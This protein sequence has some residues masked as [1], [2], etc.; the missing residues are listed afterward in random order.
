MAAGESPQ[1][2]KRCSSLSDWFNQNSSYVASRRQLSRTTF[3]QKLKHHGCLGE[4][5]CNKLFSALDR[6]GNGWITMMEFLFGVLAFSDESVD[7]REGGENDWKGGAAGESTDNAVSGDPN[8]NRY[9]EQLRRQI[10]FYAMDQDRDG[11]LNYE[12][13]YRA[14]DRWNP[15]LIRQHQDGVTYE[16]FSKLMTIEP[17]VLDFLKFKVDIVS[18]LKNESE[19]PRGEPS[20]ADRPSPSS[21]SSLVVPPL[22]EAAVAAPGQD[23]WAGDRPGDEPGTYNEG[24]DVC[25]SA[26]TVEPTDA[27]VKRSD[28]PTSCATTEGRPSTNEKPHPPDNLNL[29]GQRGAKTAGLIN[30][31]ATCY[32][33]SILQCLYMEPHFRRLVFEWRQPQ[34]DTLCYQYCL[35][36]QLQQL[37]AF[38][39]EGARTQSTQP[40]TNTFGE[41]YRV[42]TQ[43]DANEFFSILL[44][45][46]ELVEGESGATTTTASGDGAEAAT[47]G[48]A[49]PEAS[50]HG[51]TETG[52]A[53]SSRMSDAIRTLMELHVET[54]T[55]C[56]EC[57]DVSTQLEKA[58]FLTLSVK[59]G[60]RGMKSVE[61]CLEWF[62][63]KERLRGYFCHNCNKETEADNIMKLAKHPEV[64]MLH[65]SRYAY[66]YYGKKKLKH[67][68]SIPPALDLNREPTHHFSEQSLE[69]LFADDKALANYIG[70]KLLNG[71]NVYELQAVVVHSGSGAEGGHYYTLARDAEART[72]HTADDSFISEIGGEDIAKSGGP[73]ETVAFLLLYRRVG[74]SARDL[75]LPYPD[76]TT[77]PEALLKKAKEQYWN[78]QYWN[79][80]YGNNQC[81]NNHQ[82]G[83]GKKNKRSHN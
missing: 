32:M 73:G 6:D 37:F 31:G 19:L 35:R 9:L 54:S 40:L 77:I 30:Q 12:E 51:S 15:E 22:C 69:S 14:F 63:R 62:E 65:L 8:T 53:S 70:S 3:L 66:G 71:P 1:L 28:T 76:P 80:Q 47:Q 13:L 50:G 25:H 68:V 75:L 58:P 27:I 42:T 41:G 72:W 26:V 83:W 55:E 2:I 17:G 18:A 59:A 7:A 78:N 34:D 81:G 36:T 52:A 60:E 45:C 20:G 29:R 23:G 4:D 5:E 21:S 49:E 61:E 48:G 44:E 43:H 11:L 33:N 46:L 39:Q 16:D 64:L 24:D 57:N 56:L 38:M 82:D 74:S 10:G 67:K 79:N